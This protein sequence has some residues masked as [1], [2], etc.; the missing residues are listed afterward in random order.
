MDKVSY[1]VVDNLHCPSCIFTVKSTLS[2][3]LN[4]PATNVHISLVSQ[5]ITVR[6]NESITPPAIA[7]ALE[8]VG[9]EVEADDENGQASSSTSSWIPHPLAGL[10]RKRR[11]R[12]VCK[13]CQAE[14]KA[15]KG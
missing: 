3:E 2:D 9:F 11:H 8:K 7:H 15:E 12:E 5:T 6:H 10:K 4:I 13:S 14:H 1:F